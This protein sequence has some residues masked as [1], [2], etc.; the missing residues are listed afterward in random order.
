MKQSLQLG[1]NQH[2][3]L[4]P[5]LQQA[6][7]LLQLSTL[8]LQQEIQQVVEANPMLESMP[9]EEGNEV[10]LDK[11]LIEQ[12]EDNFE[13]QWSSLYSVH[14]RSNH[15][16]CDYNFDN[17]YC[18]IMRLQDHLHW[19]LEL[20]TMS[21][22]DRIIATS[23]ID[24]IDDD[25]L[26]TLTVEDLYASL[27][28]LNLQ[29]D[30]I[31][32][33]RHRIQQF[34]PLGCA[35]LDLGEVLLVQLEQFTDHAYYDLAKKIITN[36]L[37]LLAQHN[38]RQMI[39]KYKVSEDNIEYALQL[40]K[41]LNPRPGSLIQQ[42][43]TEYIIPDL[44]V[45]KINGTW[46]VALTQN[47]LPHLRIN[48]GYAALIRRADNSIDNTFLKDNLREAKWFLKNIKSR[49]ETILKVGK[50]IVE[51]QKDFLENGEAS[52]KSLIL[53]DV[54]NALDLHESTISRVTT[55]KFMH[56]PRGIFELK[57]F[58]SSHVNTKS[59]GECSSTAIRAVIKKI[60][61]TENSKKPFSD[62]KIAEL[63]G[64][65]GIQVARRTVAKYRE[66]L[67]IASSNARKTLKSEVDS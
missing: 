35:S 2:L 41:R 26:L 9:N 29:L 45:K 17:F 44:K 56:T 64:N 7:R 60:I 38:Y 5:Q 31:H 62:N 27:Q 14:S 11:N 18:T 42:G 36:D 6:I 47:T 32:A 66:D 22:V 50:W 4:T 51:F 34:D 40:I 10:T 30:E 48:K 52:M 58:F 28:N 23:I 55:Q 19:Q 24:A 61:A 33:V 43:L 20:T 37:V 3:S 67:G 54:A 12:K 53:S 16:D 15:D 39:K 8:D 63:I 25:G 1:I 59:G 46:Q 13:Y 57:Y 21:D 65:Q 49:Q